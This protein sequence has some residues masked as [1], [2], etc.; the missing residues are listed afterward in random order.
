MT[1]TAPSSPTQ[2]WD[3]LVIGGGSSGCVLARRLSEDS[4]RRVALLESGPRLPGDNALAAVRNG[5]QPAV[6]PGL[7]WKYRTAIKGDARPATSGGSVFDYEAGRVLGGSSAVNATQALRGTPADHADWAAA[8]GT[9]WSWEEVLP[10][11]KAVEDDPLGPSELHGRDGP[12][13]IR[14]ESR[15]DLTPIHSSLMQACLDAGFAETPDHNDPGTTGVGVIPKNVVDGVRMSAADTYL[16]PALSRPNLEVHCGVHVHYLLWGADGRCSGVLADVDGELRTYH[17]D[18]VVLCAG[19]MSTPA[20]LMRSGVGDPAALRDLRIA[21]QLPLHGVGANFMEH[22]VVG[23]W[24]VP[25]PGACT[26]G[27]PLRQTLLRFDSRRSGHDNDMHLCMMSGIDARVMFPHLAG[28]DQAAAVV[29]GLTVC[30]NKPRSTGHVRLASADPHAAPIVTNN[31][32]GVPDDAAPLRDAVQLGWDLLQRP[33][34]R[35]KFQRLLA[36]TDGMVRSPTALDQAVRSFVRPSAHGC[37]SARMGLSPD[38]GAVVDPQGRLHGA[39]N[40]WV[41]DTSVFPVIPSAP[42]HLTCLMVAEKIA[43]VLA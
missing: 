2:H 38:D 35:D 31:L 16:A 19:V 33:V 25:K 27:E 29:A 9:A 10:A 42:P 21:V 30:F 3:V 5:H 34:L 43:H 24:G 32:L 20:I 7:N 22:P 41:A 18:S 12:M 39:A 28:A 26:A 11:F 37:G 4:A 23:L 1:A 6:V 36:W 17:A 40:V 14:R 15:E 8:C 13:P